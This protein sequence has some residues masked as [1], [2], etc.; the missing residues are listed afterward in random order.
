M[1]RGRFAQAITFRKSTLCSLGMGAA[2]LMLHTGCT[3][4]KVSPGNLIG[5]DTINQPVQTQEP[6]QTG[7][8]EVPPMEGGDGSS[9]ATGTTAASG[10]TGTSGTSGSSGTSAPTGTTC[11]PNTPPPALTCGPG[12]WK[13]IGRY[14][15]A[16]SGSSNN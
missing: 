12:E 7:Q 4:G 14:E 1:I 5:I 8:N 13:A 9:G 11:N 6:G 3:Q 15:C 16:F 2:A 10:P